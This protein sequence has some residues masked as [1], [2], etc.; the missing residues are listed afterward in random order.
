MVTA[1]GLMSTH[2]LKTLRGGRWFWL[3][4]CGVWQ[5]NRKQQRSVFTK[6]NRNPRERPRFRERKA[7]RRGLL[8]LLV[9]HEFLRN[10]VLAPSK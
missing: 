4:L 1:I 7:F 5:A 6:K 2:L 10:G 8:K 3:R 9:T